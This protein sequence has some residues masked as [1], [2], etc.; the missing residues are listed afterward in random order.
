MTWSH[1]SRSKPLLK[2]A[3]WCSCGAPPEPSFPTHTKRRLSNV[4]EAPRSCV[5]GQ[6]T[7]KVTLAELL[8]SLLSAISLY[9]STWAFEVN[10]PVLVG[11]LITMVICAVV[12][13][14]TVPPTQRTSIPKYSAGV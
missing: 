7:A 9:G 10:V 6:L 14:G 4:A 13:V 12:R 8:L 2:A 11:A 3:R 1:G 5:R